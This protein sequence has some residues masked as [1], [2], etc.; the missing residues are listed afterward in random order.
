MKRKK[1]IIEEE[2]KEIP[3]FGSRDQIINNADLTC[4]K[5]KKQLPVRV[6]LNSSGKILTNCTLCGVDLVKELT[7]LPVKFTL[8]LR[9]VL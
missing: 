2:T 7:I 3:M 9:R 6:D 5:C 1:I 8:E 4:P